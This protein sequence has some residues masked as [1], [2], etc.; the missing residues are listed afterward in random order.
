MDDQ[1]GKPTSPD[2][3]ADTEI[4]SF[5][6]AS[7]RVPVDLRPGD[8][9]NEYS[10]E[11]ELGRGGMGTTYA[12]R[13]TKGQRFALKIAGDDPLRPQN[14]KDQLRRDAELASL[15]AP[16]P[17]VAQVY[18]MGDA[19]IRGVS[20]AYLRSELVTGPPLSTLLESSGRLSSEAVRHLWVAVTEGLSAIHDAGVLHLDL[21]PSNLLLDR[22][23]NTQRGL[24]DQLLHATPKII[25]FG[26]SRKRGDNAATSAGVEGTPYYM[27]PEQCEGVEPSP[28]SDIYTLGV[29]FFQIATG[30]LPFTG[31]QLAV[32]HQHVRVAPPLA[33][34]DGRLGY[35]L[36]L[37]LSR[38]LLKNPA[39]RY[40]NPAEL[41]V[42]LCAAGGRDF[43]H[44]DLEYRR[45]HETLTLS[46][47]VPRRAAP[48]SG[49]FE[50]F[51]GDSFEPLAQLLWLF[52]RL[53]PS[54]KD[55]VRAAEWITQRVDELRETLLAEP[56][57]VSIE[58]DVVS[59]VLLPRLRRSLS[60]LNDSEA[61]PESFDQEL[62]EIEANALALRELGAVR[63]QTLL[64]SWQ[65][66]RTSLTQLRPLE[67][68]GAQNRLV[69]VRIER[70]L[71]E[72]VGEMRWDLVEVTAKID[73]LLASG[74]A[75]WA[76]QELLTFE[77]RHPHADALEEIAG[78]LGLL[79]QRVQ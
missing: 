61:L 77:R 36:S 68:T 34:L 73:A 41:R 35:H 55:V 25:D 58:L 9:L 17:A 3:V 7:P 47:K 18:E 30:T 59:A 74:D 79:R 14:A 28:A 16:C 24:T 66:A 37:I 51:R 62:G 27:S 53:R 72:R 2:R 20:V 21:K 78:P 26:I 6:P 40:P 69:R 29:A 71:D 46:G 60:D 19:E 50:R 11:E 63:R 13:D 67:E 54:A 43:A 12:C 39:D 57:R 42:D 56:D 32:L 5:A 8:R 23:I 49:P 45:D 38:C 1:D 64:E 48:S 65:V 4:D 31:E 75:K 10:I 70:D 15:V 76:A 22:P 52:T 33:E 44:R